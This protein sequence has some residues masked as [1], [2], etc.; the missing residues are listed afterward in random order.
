M[1]RS[2]SAMVGAL[3]LPDGTKGMADASMTRRPSMPRTTEPL[4][5][6]RQRVAIGPHAAGAHRVPVG[7]HR[8]AAVIG[9]FLIARHVL[10]GQ[11]LM[12]DAGG[13]RVSAP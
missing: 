12:G 3:V 6:H 11:H 4:V 5:E 8:A 1:A 13:E 9:E 7:L 2:A 10:A